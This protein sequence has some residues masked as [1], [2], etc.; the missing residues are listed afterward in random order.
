MQGATIKIKFFIERRT[1]M[2]RFIQRWASVWL[3]QSAL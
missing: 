3:S 2:Y 1:L